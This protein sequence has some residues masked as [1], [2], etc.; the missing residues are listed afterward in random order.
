MRSF[1]EFA[2]QP[3]V[4]EM[5]KY[6]RIV[7]WRSTGCSEAIIAASSGMSD[8]S[9][10]MKVLVIGKSTYFAY[11]ETQDGYGM[12]YGG[13]FTYHQGWKGMKVLYENKARGVCMD[14]AAFE[15]D[16]FKQLGLTAYVR[17][18]AMLNHM[19]TVLKVKNSDGK[20]LWIPFD[21]GIGPAKNLSLPSSRRKYVDT[22][23]KRY[24]LYL[25]HI[26]G[27][28]TKKNFLG[29]DFK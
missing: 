6:F 26:K 2:A 15:M 24:K 17:D 18:S 4:D 13:D 28:P 22:E 20:T 25:S 11:R 29:G 8:L 12:V 5:L 21:Y 1:D 10:A 23:E 9:D 19:W 16:V 7:E 14:Y 27:A 3:K